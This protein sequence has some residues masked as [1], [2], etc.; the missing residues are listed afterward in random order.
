MKY[1]DI[2][3]K[4]TI[5]EK[6]AFLTESFGVNIHL[7]AKPMLPISSTMIRNLIEEGKP[8]SGLVDPGVEAYIQRKKMYLPDVPEIPEIPDAMEGEYPVIG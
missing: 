4:M 1:Q 3:E 8:I 5:E 2:I 6:A 7:L